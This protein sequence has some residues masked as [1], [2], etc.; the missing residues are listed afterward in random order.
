MSRKPSYEEL[1][2][3]VEEL[4]RQLYDAKEELPSLRG[5]GGVRRAEEEP[6]FAESDGREALLWESEAR[7]KTIL[8]S[9]EVGVVILDT[10]THRI[11]SVNPKA[12]A[13]IGASEDQVLG[14]VCHKFICPKEVGQ[15]P[16]SNSGKALEASERVL[17][18]VQ[19]VQV[20]IM[21]SAVRTRLGDQECIVE[22]FVDITER[23][24][25]EEALRVQAHQLEVV[26][27]VSEEIAREL[28]LDRLLELILRHASELVEAEGGVIVLWD[29]DGKALFPRL[30]IGDYWANLPVRPIPLGEGVVGRVAQTLEGIIVND[31]R[32]WS[33]ARPTVIQLSR[34][35]AALGQPLVH[36]DKLI[37]AISLAHTDGR[38][39]F[40]Q[41]HLTLLNLFANQAAIA[42]ENARLYEEARQ[43]LEDRKRAEET[44]RMR[45]HQ[46]EVVRGVVEEIT[47]E[48]NLDRLLDLILRRAVEITGAEA[49]AITLWDEG[50]RMLAPRVS[51]GELFNPT[52]MTPFPIGEGA[53]GRV[54]ASRKG[55][56][57]NDY[58][59]WPGAR[60]VAIQTTA[61]RA[62]LAEPMLYRDKLVGVINVANTDLKGGFEEHHLSTLRLFANQAAIAIENA[63]LY[64]EAQTDAI[65]LHTRLRQI[66]EAEKE[67]ED[68]T[69]QLYQA[70]KLEAIGTLAGGIAHDFNNILA[71][72]IMGAELALMTIPVENQ[73]HPMMQKVLTAGMRAKDLVQQILA[74]SRQSDLERRPMRLGPLLKE[75]IKLARASL[76]ATIE[77]RQ[78]VNPQ[79]DLVLANPTQV[80]QVMMN[81]FANA[82][83]AMRVNGGV[84]EVTLENEI[85]EEGRALGV[86]DIRAG[87]FAKLTVSDSGHGMDPSTLERI[88][89]PFFTTK[90]RGEGTGLGLS[91][92]HGIIKSYDGAIT[93]KSQPGQG[94]SFTIWIPLV[95]AEAKDQAPEPVPLPLGHERILFVDDEPFIVEISRQILE[96]LGYRVETRTDPLDALE[97][98]KRDPG[99]YDLVITD[100]TMPK[101][102]GDR[103]ALEILRIRPEIP[104]LL[105]TGFSERMTEAAA[106][107]MG[108]IGFIMKPIAVAEIARKVRQ[109]LG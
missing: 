11:V 28:N 60:P 37:G 31:Y 64:D 69:R 9:L 62:V 83:H 108:I 90:E 52:I 78:N 109:A 81:L 19:G 63:S 12:L 51:F 91:I 30:R 87:H 27:G 97:I 61:V 34:V 65:E 68:L 35:T 86:P 25:V 105:C 102:T 13:M 79:K 104:I 7:L 39:E 77:I 70:Q 82:G 85:V 95:E 54:A 75:T 29:E 10:E 23:K 18:T 88:F 93:A 6:K 36:R 15:C 44:L 4:T 40:G 99:L 26:R 74:F 101:M 3:Q 45:T 49:G 96:R 56:I 80:H 84:L 66:A 17:L 16:I 58:R 89:N 32:T 5:T 22:S 42:I 98:F 1:E 20:P 47:R 33:G 43:E 106:M 38:G 94:T 92:V 53:G 2:R 67:K 46:L 57:V 24:R 100:M 41:H 107:E 72:I 73:A 76:P 59:S 14:Q 71:P 21:K 48:L 103:L 50:K 8:D 55:L